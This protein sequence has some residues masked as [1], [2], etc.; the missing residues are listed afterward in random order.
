MPYDWSTARA[1][2]LVH[3]R[4]C[5]WDVDR[6]TDCQVDTIAEAAGL[7]TPRPLDVMRDLLRRAVPDGR[8]QWAVAL[9]DG[10]GVSFGRDHGLDAHGLRD[11]R[12]IEVQA[13]RRRSG[14]FYTV[15]DLHLEVGADGDVEDVCAS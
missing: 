15:Y 5:R 10:S 8:R 2:R 13:L 6:L 12:N 1:R 9:H 7:E 14:R 3:D 11:H 4:G